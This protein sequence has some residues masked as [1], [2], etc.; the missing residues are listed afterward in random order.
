VAQAPRGEWCILA[1]LL[2]GLFAVL[3]SL[4]WTTGVT[5][6]EPAHL[7][8]AH[9]YWLG[10]DN[11]EPGDVPPLIK[12]AGG[13]V[14]HLTGL[15]VP[16]DR[17]ELWERRPEWDLAQAMM[18]RM[19]LPQLQRIFF[20]SRLPLTVFP[21]LTCA[22]LWWWARQLYSPKTAIWLAYFA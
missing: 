16:Y 3:A 14:S 4:A 1:V 15:P 17:R 21:V 5:V 7:L 6:D 20:Y 11:L 8:S 10:R 12:L 2:A 13:W 9:L 18:E 22:V 19:Q